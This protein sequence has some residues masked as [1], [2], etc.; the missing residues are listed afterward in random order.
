LNWDL[1]REVADKLD[2][3]RKRT[4]KVIN[5]IVAEKIKQQE[6]AEADEESDQESAEGQHAAGSN[7]IDLE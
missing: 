5:E 7:E 1:K 3:L 6:E 2:V 4:Q